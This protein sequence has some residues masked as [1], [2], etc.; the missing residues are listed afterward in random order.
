MPA[1]RAP[2][3]PATLSSITTQRSGSTPIWAAANR[4]RSGAGLPR[5]TWVA[6]KI[7]GA[8]WSFEPGA[9]QA[10]MDLSG[11]PLEATH[12]GKPSAAMASPT[13]RD[14]AEVVGIEAE[15]RVLD[16][17]LE[18]VGQRTADLALDDPPRLAVGHAEETLQHAVR[19]DRKAVPRQRFRMRA[20]GRS[21]RCRPAR[22]RNRR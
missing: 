21:P 17:G 19:R 16:L 7:C 2:V 5:L 22:R 11:V 4:N 14:R 15:R 6:E 18:A 13:W 12:F 1:A 9:G 10:V 8:S 3:T 20:T